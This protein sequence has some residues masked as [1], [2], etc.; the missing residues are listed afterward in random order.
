MLWIPRLIY[1]KV[2]T[3]ADG[4]P[5]LPFWGGYEHCSRSCLATCTNGVNRNAPYKVKVKGSFD[6]AVDT[7]A[8]ISKSEDDTW[9]PD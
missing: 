4:F 2:K 3:K 7:K 8:D 1:Q 9:T 5:R 6:Y